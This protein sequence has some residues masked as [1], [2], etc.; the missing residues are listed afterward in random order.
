MTY[1]NTNKGTLGKNKR[2][3]SDTHPDYTGQLNIDGVEYWLSGWLKSNGQT[4]EK[5]F[6]L[7]VKPKE[8]RQEQSARSGAPVSG[9]RSLFFPLIPPVPTAACHNCHFAADIGA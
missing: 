4:G 1:D 7:A 5:F 2:K 8:Q 3:E 6:S 9:H